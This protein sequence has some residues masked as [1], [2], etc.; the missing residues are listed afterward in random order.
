MRILVVFY[1]FSLGNNVVAAFAE[2]L[3]QRD[4]RNRK[5]RLQEEM[6]ALGHRVLF[7]QSFITSSIL[8]GVTG[9]E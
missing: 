7:N 6:E 3:R 2:I 1:I 9:V 4:F 5:G 8:S